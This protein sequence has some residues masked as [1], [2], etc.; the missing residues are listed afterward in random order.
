MSPLTFILGVPLLAAVVMLFLPRNLRFLA[1][2]IA[3]AA[4]GL[5]M[6]A[7]FYVFAKFQAGA[8]T[9]QFVQKVEWIDALGISYYVGVDGINVGLVLMG[10]IVAFAAA[11]VSWEIK[12]REKEFYV[13]LL[14]MSGGIL[15]AFASL[16][17]FFFYFFHE[18]ALVPTFIMIGVWG[19]GTE[20]NY[21]AFKMTLYLSLGAL[22]ALLGLIVL[23]VQ[24]GANT[25]DIVALTAH[26]K[27]K[28]LPAAIQSIIFPLLLF[29]FGILVSLWPFH[30]WAP[31]G[32]GSAPTATSMLHAGVLKKFGLYGL[33]RVALP[34]LPDAL[35]SGSI[36]GPGWLDILVFLCLGNIL[37]CGLVAIRQKN[38]NL[39]IGNSSVAHMGFIFL[40]IA[41][42]TLVGIT[43]AV[44]IMV[45]HGLLAALTF[46]VSG[47]L[48]QQTRTLEIDK[49]GGLLRAVPFIGAAM[50]MAMMAGCGLPGFANFV[51]EAM[52]FFGAWKAY[53]VAT[54]FACWGGLVIGAVYMLRAIRNILHGEL[55]ADFKNI[56]D[57][58]TPWRK[59]PFVVLIATLLWFGFV[60]GSLTEKIKPDA[61]KIV[62]MAKPPGATE[63]GDTTKTASAH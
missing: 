61:E 25:F 6:L 37:F 7:A 28:P 40:G 3:L 11:C 44:V 20:R 22:I 48:Y 52:V 4:T 59:L 30:T 12:D 16:D 2:L 41:S 14:L 51:G 29:G 42:L 23:Y 47:Y 53:P 60:P 32:Y 1:R 13:L 26:I 56:T 58:A 27:A 8:E 5:S 35:N 17:L 18:L 38:L 63:T 34:L 21:A 10:A 36:F 62:Q 33:I 19:K 57:A 9:Y 55:V 49:M 31:I 15:G 43:G 45:A 50:I 39:L 54:A 46:A 24:S